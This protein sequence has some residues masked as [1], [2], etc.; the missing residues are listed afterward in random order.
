MLR[1][2]HRAAPCRPDA[3]PQLFALTMPS[4]ILCPARPSRAVARA[5]LLARAVRVALLARPTLHCSLAARRAAHP[6][7]PLLARPPCF[8]PTIASARPAAARCPSRPTP[9]AAHCS[10]ASRCPAHPA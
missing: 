3:R 1:A 5:V 8:S 10:P 7:S 4:T 9:V 6:P 2:R